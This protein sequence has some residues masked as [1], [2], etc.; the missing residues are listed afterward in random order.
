MGADQVDFPPTLPLNDKVVW[1]LMELMGYQLQKYM[2]GGY[3]TSPSHP[4]M[5]LV[6]MGCSAASIAPPHL[7]PKP[8]RFFRSSTDPPDLTEPTVLI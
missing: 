3:Y 7:R 6:S 8:P 5:T 4:R 1:D 2:S